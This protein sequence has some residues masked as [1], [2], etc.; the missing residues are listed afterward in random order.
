M[1]NTILFAA[2]NMLI[3]QVI[4][5]RLSD[6]GYYVITATDGIEAESLLMKNQEIDVLVTEE[7]LPL[8]GGLELIALCNQLNIPSIII[9]DADLESKILEAFDLGAYDFI[10]KPYSPN[11]L[12]VRIK[13][14]FKHYTK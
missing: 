12:V 6:E 14:I 2:T 13:N 9:S 10:D 8:K 5:K 7:L 4:S 3:Q 11:E 1:P